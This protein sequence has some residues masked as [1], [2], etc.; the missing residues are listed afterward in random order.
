[1]CCSRLLEIAFVFTATGV[2]QVISTAQMEKG[3]RKLL[4]AAPDLKLDV[5][6]ATEQIA[7]FIARA[8]VDD[9]LPHSFV[10]DIPAGGHLSMHYLV[11]FLRHTAPTLGL[12][13]WLQ[14]I[15]I[16]P[17]IYNNALKIHAYD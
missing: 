14:E 1:M 16:T 13:Q 9:V 8:V 5:P 4:L 2:T 17:G 10:E 7:I 11:L 15:P 12:L 3:F 6:D